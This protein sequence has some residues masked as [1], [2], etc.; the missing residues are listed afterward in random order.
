MWPWD[1]PQWLTGTDWTRQ[2]GALTRIH[3]PRLRHFPGSLEAHRATQ[4]HRIW[5]ERRAGMGAADP[6]P[7]CASPSLEAGRDPPSAR[8]QEMI[9]ADAEEKLGCLR[10]GDLSSLPAFWVVLR[11]W[12]GRGV[13]CSL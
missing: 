7:A 9:P 11:P 5:D 3:T 13:S 1:Q 2:M 10:K 4:D 12:A 6:S 8:L